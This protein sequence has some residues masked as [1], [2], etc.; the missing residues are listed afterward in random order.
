MSQPLKK[1]EQAISDAALEAGI[2][3]QLLLDSGQASHAERAAFAQWL[4]ANEEHALVWRQLGMLDTQLRSL[5]H[6]AAPGDRLRS[7]LIRPPRRRLKQGGVALGLTLVIALGLGVAGRFQTM[8]G[9]FADYH[10]ATGE[11]RSIVL[12]DQSVMVMNT[13]TAVDVNFDEKRRTLTLREGEVFIETSHA[14][15]AEQRPFLVMTSDG[16]LRAL[17][18]RFIV[19]KGDGKTLLTVMESAVLAQPAL[20]GAA[21]SCATARKAMQSQSLIM[22]REAAS[23][24]YEAEAQA[25]AWKDGMFV[26]ENVTLENVVAELARYHPGRLSVAP[27][28]ATLRVTGT[29]P[30]GDI[31]L[32]LASLTRALP[33][34]RVQW[35]PLWVSIEPSEKRPDQSR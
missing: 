20:C 1:D 17:G 19:R 25:D 14:N 7:V 28:V 33:V 35:T 32:A 16:S 18:T 5:P 30:L 10:T 34:K 9:L 22:T 4:A 26:V 15:P 29:V 31:D 13:R 21:A 24:V 6:Q 2:A 12:P 11:R 8:Q 3:W 23:E 27:E